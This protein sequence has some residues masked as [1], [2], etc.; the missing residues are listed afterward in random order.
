MVGSKGEQCG[1]TEQEGAHLR[2]P[3]L[4][5]GPLHYFWPAE[6]VRAF[7]S[8]ACDWPL[9]LVYLGEVVCSKR[10]QLR[11]AD[12]LSLAH[13]LRESGKQVVLS[14][15]SL[16]E[17]ESELSSLKRLVENG[18]FM[19]EA[20]DLSAVQLCRERRLSF[21]GGPTLNVYSQATLAML[22]EDGLQR[23]VPGVEQGEQQIEAIMS[24]LRSEGRPRP[25]LEVQIWGRLPLAWSARCFTARA[26]DLGKDDCGF[27]CLD[28]EQGLP[29]RT[30]EGEELMRIN[31]IQVQG[32]EVTDLGPQLPSLRRLGVDWLRVLPHAFELAPVIE[33]FALALQGSQ[34]PPRLG[35]VNGYW[36]GAAGRT[37]NAGTVD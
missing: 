23:W 19:I 25:E 20:N 11:F 22:Q 32:A 7:Y 13:A 24:A 6:R 1:A 30:R 18:E 26:H 5:L 14:G 4:S 15:L 2:S 35:A 37:A 17:S 16:I 27:R 10:R 8:A 21:V 9:Q 34:P 28:D 33:H 29:L 12:W 3:G 31:G 36:S